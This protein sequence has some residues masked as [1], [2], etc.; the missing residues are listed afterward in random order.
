MYT[1]VYSPL[2]GVA[3]AR[4]ASSA[5]TSTHSTTCAA[6]YQKPSTVPIA[7][8]VAAPLVKLATGTTAVVCMRAR[9]QKMMHSATSVCV[10]AR[11]RVCAYVYMYV[12]MYVCMYVFMYLPTSLDLIRASIVAD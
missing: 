10:C 2:R 7:V 9:S 11:A 8:A 4:T 6:K 1:Y 12:C 5:P 3:T